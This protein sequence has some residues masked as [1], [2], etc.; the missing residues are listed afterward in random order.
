MFINYTMIEPQIRLP[1]NPRNWTPEIMKANK[2]AHIAKQKAIHRRVVEPSILKMQNEIDVNIP[3][4]RDSH[5]LDD[6]DYYNEF[7]IDNGDRVLI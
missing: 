3:D 5:D 7:T 4:S 2:D 1:E 6:D